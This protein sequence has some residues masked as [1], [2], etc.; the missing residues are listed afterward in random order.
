LTRDSLSVWE[1]TVCSS[2]HGPNST[3][4]KDQKR[5][6]KHTEDLDYLAVPR[7]KQHFVRSAIC[8]AIER[9]PPGKTGQVSALSA[10]IE[11]ANNWLNRGLR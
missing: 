8:K 7:L 2:C 1:L 6:E 3:E 4:E 9:W 10:V 5:T 11:S